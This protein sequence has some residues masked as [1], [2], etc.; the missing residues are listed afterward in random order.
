M[1]DDFYLAKRCSIATEALKDMLGKSIKACYVATIW[2]ENYSGQKN[3]T[4]A[5]LKIRVDNYGAVKK[6]QKRKTT[7]S[8]FYCDQIIV[9]FDDGRLILMNEGFICKLDD[10]QVERR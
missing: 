5:I 10:T 2:S 6:H 8:S 1:N 7:H 3:D 4:W 9:E